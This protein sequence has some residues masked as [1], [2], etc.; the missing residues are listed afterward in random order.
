[1]DIISACLLGIPCRYDGKSCKD[2]IAVKLFLDGKVLPV[3][4]E[5]LGELDT[6]RVPSEIVSGTGEDVLEGHSA[7]LDAT[8]EDLTKAFILGAK[9]TLAVCKA[10]GA[11]KA[12][13]KSKSPSCGSEWIHDGSFTGILKQGYGV[14]AALL[15][16]EGIKVVEME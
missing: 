16:R 6:P 14:T 7:V 8:G 5:V 4:P 15:Q 12:Y 9:R 1:M 10:L 3:C 11:K 2:D 13:L